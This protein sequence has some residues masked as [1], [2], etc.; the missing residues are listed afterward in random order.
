[1]SEYWLFK[2]YYA[3]THWV[4]K[5]GG[6]KDNERLNNVNIASYVTTRKGFHSSN[7]EEGFHIS[8]GHYL[9]SAWN[10]TFIT[11]QNNVYCQVQFMRGNDG[12]E[13]K[14]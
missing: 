9:T 2:S 3:L 7:V 8:L 14:T 13:V 6:N 1:M 5:T 12:T 10:L 4:K 11:S